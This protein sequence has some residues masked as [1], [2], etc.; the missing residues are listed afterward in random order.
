MPTAGR[1][2]GSEVIAGTWT[3]RSFRNDTALIADDAAAALALIFGEGV[4]DLR[5]DDETHVSGALGMTT[6]YALTLTGT[7]DPG[8][9]GG[10]VGFGII[11]LGIEGTPTAG[12]RYDYRGVTGFHWPGAIA[13]VPCLLGTVLRVNAHGP[14]SPAGVTASF[15]A[16]RHPDDPPPRG[17]RRNPLIA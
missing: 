8:P 5:G 4:F 11:G 2:G 3:Y 6:D 9:P 7:I 12:W 16:V 17:A 13:Q 1:P 15:V 10:P 14:A